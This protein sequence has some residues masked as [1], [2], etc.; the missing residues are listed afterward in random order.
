MQ[1][2]FEPVEINQNT[3]NRKIILAV[4]VTLCIIILAIACALLVRTYVFTTYMVDG[5]SMNPT[6]DGGV[7]ASAGSDPAYRTDGETLILNKLAKI[8]RGDIIV[9]TPT[10]W[11]ITDV[12]GNPSTLVKRVIGVAGDRIQIIGNVVYLNGTALDEQYIAE[13]MDFRYDGLD[14]YV[15]EGHIFCMGDNRNNSTDCRAYGE[16]SL[17]CV[18]GKCFLIKG[19][20]GKLRTCK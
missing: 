5:H 2:E 17:D 1:N 20:N 9:F 10:E 12:Y 4:I 15:S 13:P 3:N 6:L 8:K 14:V 7:T 11:N 16:V 18:V 19:T